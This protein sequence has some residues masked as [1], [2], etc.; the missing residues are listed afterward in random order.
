MSQRLGQL[1]GDGAIS[2]LCNHPPSNVDWVANEYLDRAKRGAW[3]KENTVESLKCWNLE[4]VIVAE[5]F[6]KPDQT[7]SPLMNFQR[8]LRMAIRTIRAKYVY[9]IRGIHVKNKF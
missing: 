5:D 3:K 2:T 8:L 6:G 1:T 9:L 4:R 7:I